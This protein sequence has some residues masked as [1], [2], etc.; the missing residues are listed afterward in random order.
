MEPEETILLIGVAA[1]VLYFWSKQSTSA[2]VASN[3]NPTAGNAGTPVN[4]NTAASLIDSAGSL[5]GPGQGNGQDGTVAALDQGTPGDGTDL[6]AGDNADA[7]QGFDV[8]E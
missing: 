5:L 4:S 8:N 7:S 1:F 2:P 6:S 3:A